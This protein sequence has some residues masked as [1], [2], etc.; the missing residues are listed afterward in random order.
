MYI[1]YTIIFAFILSVILII[2]CLKVMFDI[3]LHTIKKKIQA[4]AV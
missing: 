3:V 1:I 2:N 4:A